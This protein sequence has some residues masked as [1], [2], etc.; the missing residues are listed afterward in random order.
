MDSLPTPEHVLA[1][2]PTATIFEAA[3]ETGGMAANIRP[4]VPGRRMAGMAVTVR[5]LPGQSLAVLQAIEV[6]PSGSV[7]VIDAGGSDQATIWGGTSSLAC[8]LRNLAGCVTN[9]A[10]RDISDIRELG[11]PVFAAGICIRGT[12]KSHP[13][14]Q[15]I[16]VSVGEVVVEPGDFVVGDDDGVVVVPHAALAEIAE[17]ARLRRILEDD[18]EARQRRG[19]SVLSVL[20]LN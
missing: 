18:R 7:L 1:A 2:L 9:A 12:Q 14:W 20:G 3:G 17:K 15:D 11:F 16:P 10:A 19:E 5:C 4:I 6:A 8:K 13:G